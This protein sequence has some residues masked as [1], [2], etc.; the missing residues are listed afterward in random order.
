MVEDK[1][2]RLLKAKSQI[3]RMSNNKKKLVMIDA[4]DRLLQYYSE[5]K[6]NNDLD[7]PSEFTGKYGR[8]TMSDMQK[9]IDDLSDNAETL[10]SFYQKIIDIYK[11]DDFCSYEYNVFKKINMPKMANA[12]YDFFASLGNDVLGIYV[13][14]MNHHNI[15]L[16]NNP[17]YA[18]YA[19]DTIPLDYPCIVIEN[20]PKYLQF[21]TTLVH[22]IG[23]AYQFY[24]QRNQ[25]NF[26]S[27]NPFVEINSLLFEK[28]FCDYLINN[29]VI[30][31][32]LYHELDNHIYFLNDVSI[33]K[34][35]TK[36]LLDKK[37]SNV[38]IYS[39]SY[40]CSVSQ[41]DVLYEIVSDCGY[42]MPNKLELSLDNFHYSIS[43]IIAMYFHEKL[44]N[45]FD[46]EWKNY[47]DFI[48]TVNYLPM[49]EI[50]NEY[51]DI[52]LI[53]NNIK[54]F[55]KSYRGR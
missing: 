25:K 22:E 35:L 49:D 9:I 38:N 19:L 53:E 45:N 30:N 46:L 7:I 16:S 51:F 14:M 32:N 20:I 13:G 8:Y 10:Y 11:K 12:V 47:K 36:L 54:K 39:L 5:L 52:N 29:H 6:N 31:D 40:D 34:A 43:N 26:S 18:G 48:C 33:S 1:K 17:D 42:I 28:L 27:F 24:L 50:I 23:H 44:K 21:Y 37:I 15:L 4:Y 3:L 55:I 41:C 2:S